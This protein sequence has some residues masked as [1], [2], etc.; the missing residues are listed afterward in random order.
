MIRAVLQEIAFFL[1]PFALWALLLAA[2]RKRVTDIEHWS[3]AA[4]WLAIGG[5]VLVIGSLLWL[6]IFAERHTGAYEPPHME[7][8]RLV[9]GRFR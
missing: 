3:R 2:Q 1:T 7:N 4:V 9:P 8:G 6:G 5:L